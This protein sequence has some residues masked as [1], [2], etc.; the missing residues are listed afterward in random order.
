MEPVSVA[1]V[2]HDT[3]TQLRR[4]AAQ[5][6]VTVSLHVQGRYPEAVAE[7][8]DAMECY[9]R[10]SGEEHPDVGSCFFRLAQIAA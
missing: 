3:A 8:R 4:V 2:L 6:G 7:Y 5:Y 9:R 1:A 10:M